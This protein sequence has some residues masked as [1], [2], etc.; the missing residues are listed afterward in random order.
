MEKP[1]YQEHHRYL[2]ELQDQPPT[3]WQFKQHPNYCQILEH[4]HKDHGNSYLTHIET[5]FPQI[6]FEQIRDYVNTNDKYGGAVK[7][8]YTTQSLRLLYCSPSSLRYIFQALLV[9]DAYNATDCT[10]MVEVGAGYGG[11]CLAI[12]MFAPSML[13]ETKT[14]KQYYMM[15]LPASCVL[16]REYLAL[17]SERLPILYMAHARDRDFNTYQHKTFFISH[18]CFS[19]LSESEQQR[20][21]D[22]ILSSCTHGMLT[23]Q[24]CFGDDISRADLLLGKTVTKCLEECPQTGPEH[25]KNYYIYF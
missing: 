7:H 6:T 18:F 22:E 23:W 4:I 17:H 2:Y 1:S 25:A 12:Q 20:Y 21:R 11:L 13:T 9:L 5:Q 14:L 8:I 24:T 16:I 15:D 3:E 19:E 10:H